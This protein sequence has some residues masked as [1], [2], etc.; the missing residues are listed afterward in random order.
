MPPVRLDRYR[1]QILDI[2]DTGVSLKMGETSAVSIPF[3][4]VHVTALVRTTNIFSVSVYAVSLCLKEVF[5]ILFS[6]R[7]VF[8]V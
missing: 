4:T 1:Y 5:E 6:A 3:D 8:L 7:A 2:I